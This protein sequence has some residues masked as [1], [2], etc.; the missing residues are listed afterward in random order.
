MALPSQ[1]NGVTLGA[2]KPASVFGDYNNIIFAI[3]Q[4]IAR[5]ETCT[6]VRVESCTNDDDLSPVGFVDVTP[7]VNQIDGNGNATPHATIF[8]IP[9]LRIQGGTNAIIMDP[10]PGDIG[11]CLFASRDISTVKVTKAQANPGSFRSYSFA[12]GLYAGGLLNGTPEQFVRFTDSGITI[13]ASST[14]TLHAPSIVIDG[15]ATISGNLTVDGDVTAQGTSLHTHRHTTTTNG[16]PT[17]GPI[18]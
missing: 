2:L 9:Y 7:L 14:I 17:S 18:P 16:N 4:A 13:Q 1:N 6:L 15:D 5:L 8:N 11:V 3:Q 10:K 12:D